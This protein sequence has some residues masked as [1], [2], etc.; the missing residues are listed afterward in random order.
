MIVMKFGGTSVADASAL[1]SVLTIVTN[2]VKQS[3]RVLVVL[4]A[5]NGTTNNLLELAR[6][7]VTDG[8]EAV[9]LCTSIIERH[10]RI[11]QDLIPSHEAACSDVTS[12]GNE[13]IRY[14]E[15]IHLLHECTNQSL[16]KIA[17]YGER[18]T[19]CILAHAL[20]SMNV[21]SR[22]FD[23]SSVIR[24]DDQYHKA[25]VDFGETRRL[26]SVSLIPE[27]QTHD[28]IV[29][30]GYIGATADGFVTT[31]GRGGS[32]Y[33]AA[34]FGSAIG[35]E[36]IQIW[37]DVSGVFSADPRMVPNARPIPSL[38]FSE[39]RELALY[40]AK[41]LHPDTIAPA[42]KAGIAVVVLNTFRPDD[43]GTMITDEDVSHSDVHAVSI[44]K[45]CTFVRGQTTDLKN[46]L[47][48]GNIRSKILFESHSIEQS[49]VVLS[50][51]TEFAKTEI[52]VA[53][54]GT[55]L[56]S[57]PAS[58]IIATG[59]GVTNADTLSVLSASCSGHNIFE[60]CAGISKLSVF[61][62][63]RPQ[64]GTPLLTTLHDSV[65]L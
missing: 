57:E 4:S 25:N 26:C 8:D 43:E 56:F 32:D 60:L 5:A 40:G 24:T 28:V 44:V 33:S 45:E 42:I 3:K 31:L 61:I 50:S 16:D 41:V 19:S 48:H 47:I 12:I 53:L 54:A 58:I 51:P 10:I 9:G 52:E 7:A 13:L 17:S 38:S 11:C 46:I 21:R 55:Q 22:L 20:Q 65:I 36:M 64:S 29:T 37:T 30:Q 23:A 1:T 39:V 2:A 27:F 14:V 6:L 35:A 15:G 34:I 62:V 49:S 59:P 18:F 63:C